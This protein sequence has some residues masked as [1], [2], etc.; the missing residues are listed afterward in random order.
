MGSETLATST[1]T[2][3]ESEVAFV[4]GSENELSEHPPMKKGVAES[5]RTLDDGRGSD[6]YLWHVPTR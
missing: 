6:W 2:T 4:G 5:Q 3:E 1:S